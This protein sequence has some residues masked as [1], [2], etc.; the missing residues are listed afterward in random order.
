MRHAV[1]LL[2]AATL[3]TTACDTTRPP[4]GPTDAASTEPTGSTATGP[5]AGA[6]TPAARGYAM[7]ADLPGMPGVIM[8]GGASVAGPPDLADMWTYGPATGWNDVTPAAVPE[9]PEYGDGVIGNAFDF[10][11]G[12]GQGVFVDIEGNAWAYDPSANAWEAAETDGGTKELLGASMA[13]DAGSDRMILF[14]G[15]SFGGGLNGETW[16]YELDSSTWE[17]MHPK[18][19][20]SPRNYPQM[21]YDP[22][23][24]RVILF[25]GADDVE[26]LRDT[27][28]YDYDSDT[29]SL[30]PTRVSPPARTYGWMV[31]DPTG[32]RTILFGGTT[33]PSEEP[34]G[35]TWAFDLKNDTW[36]ELDT[37]GP[38]PRG[39]HAMA[40]DAETKT[41]VLFGGGTS[42]EEFTAETW[43]FDPADGTWT[44]ATTG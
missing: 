13:Y 36:T 20:P 14:G 16:A 7:M 4:A 43:T 28:A 22:T 15:F 6:G 32:E 26:A 33:Y 1:R 37:T 19:S 40:Y 38:S 24:D 29:W 2:L 27:W 8:L 10:D 17:R 25:G 11:L 12:S 3:V 18:R 44:D 34:L 30:I 31:D 41:M 23:T 5:A 9:L 21:A 42:R 35:D 39:W